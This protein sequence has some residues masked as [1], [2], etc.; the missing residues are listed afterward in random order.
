MADLSSTQSQQVL[1]STLQQNPSIEPARF[2]VR[3]LGS[4]SLA[5]FEVDGKPSS[6]GGIS[7]ACYQAGPTK[8]EGTIY[9]VSDDKSPRSGDYR[10][11]ALPFRPST[12]D[13]KL[14]FAAMKAIPLQ[15]G[16]K[17]ACHLDPEAVTIVRTADNQEG[18]CIAKE[19]HKDAKCTPSFSAPALMLYSLQGEYLG[20]DIA[21]PKPFTQMEAPLAPLHNYNLEGVSATAD[22][23]VIWAACESPLRGEGNPPD[24]NMP[25]Y[26]RLL[27]QSK[28]Q[29]GNLVWQ[30]FAYKVDGVPLP[31]PLPENWDPNKLT[32]FNKTSNKE[33]PYSR[34][35][36]VSEIVALD[37]EHFLVI[38]RSF[39]DHPD[40]GANKNNIRIYSCCLPK[41]TVPLVEGEKM[42]DNPKAH[43]VKKEL[44]FDLQS[45]RHSIA[46]EHHSRSGQAIDNIEALALCPSP[47]GGHILV[48]ASDN[49]FGKYGQERTQFIAFHLKPQ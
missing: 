23:S 10:M 37:Q 41:N 5:C 6:F 40:L 3:Y 25:A 33:E 45:F 12:E 20:Q 8:G 38:E 36:G 7:G 13:F 9:L 32:K 27:R 1:G 43:L 14:D 21:L 22:G 47:D 34:E 39:S 46:A 4:Q 26:T 31:E 2:T 11:Y 16:P 49:N 30:Q 18:V 44:L 15:G 17:D 42:P 24:F 28:D 19:G 48:L 35:N 29:N